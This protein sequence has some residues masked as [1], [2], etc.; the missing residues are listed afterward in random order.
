[1]VN[2]SGSSNVV[3]EDQIFDIWNRPILKL[4]SHAGTGPTVNMS[5]PSTADAEFEYD[6][7]PRARVLKASKYG[8]SINGTHIVEQDYCLISSTELKA[9]LV[10]ARKSI[11][12]I[13]QRVLEARGRSNG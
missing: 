11:S 3:V 13:E 5:F 2:Y 10:A 7:A 1:M 8:E 4:K 6:A 9:E 12:G